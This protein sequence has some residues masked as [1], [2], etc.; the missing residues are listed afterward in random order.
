MALLAT[1]LLQMTFH[2]PFKVGLLKVGQ[3]L[4][5]TPSRCAPTSLLEGG[6]SLS[7]NLLKALYKI[8][9]VQY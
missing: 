8:S 6:L 4:N 1:I 9:S 7:I 2:L 5:S 3:S